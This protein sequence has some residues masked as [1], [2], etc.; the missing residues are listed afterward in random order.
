MG[1]A[2]NRLVHS[3]RF[4][5]SA[6]TR[7]TWRTTTQLPNMTARRIA[8]SRAFTPVAMPTPAAMWATPVK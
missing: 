4:P 6:A 7:G 1:M 2:T 3:G 5:R 8:A